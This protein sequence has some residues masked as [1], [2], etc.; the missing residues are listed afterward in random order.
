MKKTSEFNLSLI[1][2][3]GEH[4]GIPDNIYH[5]IVK[6]N[7]NE[8]TRICKELYALSETVRIETVKNSLSFSFLSEQCKGSI[9]LQQNEDYD[10]INDYFDIKVNFIVGILIFS[11]YSN[12]KIISNIDL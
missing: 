8:F 11:F 12:D 2:F 3:D 1:N 7:S 6:M 9:T 5:S 4:L 10:H